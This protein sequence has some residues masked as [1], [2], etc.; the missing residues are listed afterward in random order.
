MH[1]HD[2]GICFGT[3]GDLGTS[4]TG[5]MSQD[6]PDFYLEVLNRTDIADE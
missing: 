5:I 2:F 1:K 4:N 3:A 6:F